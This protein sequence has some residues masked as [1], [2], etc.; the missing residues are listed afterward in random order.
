MPNWC[1]GNL[2]LRGKLENVKSFLKNEIMAVDNEV[3]VPTI[4]DCPYDE[5]FTITKPEGRRMSPWFYINDTK[6]NFVDDVRIDGCMYEIDDGSA[7]VVTIIDNFT[8]AWGMEPEPYLEKAKRYNLDIKMF[9][10][11]RGLQ[12]EQL[13]EIGRTGELLRNECHSYSDFGEWMWN[14]AHPGLGG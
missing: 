3:A 11:E 9:G 12:F 6:R 13:I 10:W 8:C 4:F 14:S 1:V 2:R 7:D 5:E